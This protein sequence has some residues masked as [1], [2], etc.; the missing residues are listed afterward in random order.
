MFENIGFDKLWIYTSRL[1]P[2]WW[3]TSTHLQV[4]AT[5]ESLSERR[6][7]SQK[8]T[9]IARVYPLNCR[10]ISRLLGYIPYTVD[11]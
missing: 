7:L 3:D 4:G 2:F 5:A 10:S 1:Q 6:L 11:S 9:S 8:R